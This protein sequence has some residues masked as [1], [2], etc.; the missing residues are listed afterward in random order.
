MTMSR[1]E[2]HPVLR[3]NPVLR[4][5]ENSGGRRGRSLLIDL[6]RNKGSRLNF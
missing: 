5:T 2:T 6:S 4:S 3:S 1:V